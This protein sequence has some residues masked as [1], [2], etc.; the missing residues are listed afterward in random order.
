MKALGIPARLFPDVVMPGNVLGELAPS[1]REELQTGRLTVINAASHDTAS[2][3]AAAPAGSGPFAYISTGT[4]S[5]MGVE[6]E[7][8]VITPES[9]R[10]GYTNEGGAFGKTVLLK[11]I[12]GLW[13]LQECKRHWSGEGVNW[14]YAQLQE[15]AEREPG[16]QSFVDPAH[17]SFLAPGDMPRRVQDY[18]RETGQAVPQTKA[19]IVR[20]ILDSLAL[21]FRQT[22]E[23]LELLTRQ[24]FP[25]IHMVGGGVQ[26]ELLCRLTA[27]ATGRPVIAGPVEATA[28]GN[29]LVQASAHGEISGLNEIREIVG[30]SFP[31]ATYEPGHTGNQWQASYEKYAKLTRTIA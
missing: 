18:C 28:I 15:L 1:V 25:V 19:A 23:E 16:H 20:C 14:S 22:L 30:R 2:A 12:M 4:W 6:R 26:N 10:L 17:P 13:L 9:G 31:P 8:P 24:S 7:S 5:L 3:I 21:K 29:L 11:N 27:E